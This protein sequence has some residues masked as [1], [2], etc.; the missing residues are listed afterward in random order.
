MTYTKTILELI[1]SGDNDSIRKFIH[2][3]PE[4]A[5]RKTDQGSVNLY[6][7]DRFTLLG[8]ASYFGRYKTVL[9]LLVLNAD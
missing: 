6:L 9:L 3:D 8:L 7:T 5:D 1:W 4:L 2:N